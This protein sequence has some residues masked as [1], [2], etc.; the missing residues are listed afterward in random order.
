MRP[1]HA[2][3]AFLALF[4]CLPV[5]TAQTTDSEAKAKAEYRVLM[6]KVRKSPDPKAWLRLGDWIERQPVRAKTQQD[7]LRYIR[8]QYG[9]AARK[10][11]GDRDIEGWLRLAREMEELLD[12]DSVSR[13]CLSEAL[14]KNPTDARLLAALKQVK[15]G[16]SDAASIVFKARKEQADERRSAAEFR[17]LAQWCREQ[18]AHTSQAKDWLDY[19]HAREL[20][21]SNRGGSA[22]DPIRRAFD[23]AALKMAAPT[24]KVRDP[25]LA[26][27]IHLPKRKWKGLQGAEYKNGR[28]YRLEAGGEV[29]Y[30]DSLPG[31]DHFDSVWK[32]GTRT[33]ASQFSDTQIMIQDHKAWWRLQWDAEV[34]D[35]VSH[36]LA[37]KRS[38]RVKQIAVARDRLARAES[39]LQRSGAKIDKRP[40]ETVRLRQFAERIAREGGRVKDFSRAL[41]S[42]V[43][44]AGST[45]Y[46]GHKQVEARLAIE[47][48][49]Q[50]IAELEAAPLQ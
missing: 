20:Y 45:R 1:I 26:V 15:H 6:Q 37:E 4:T 50:K 35:W 31:S 30:S 28:L 48:W 27:G 19:A 43:N 3:L 10:K 39:A 14:R 2:L 18:I 36:T 12:S 22:T 38:A 16:Q 46:E 7:W 42:I 8:H 34:R 32:R 40:D 23:A 17:E 29:S 5:L 47:A 11:L 49:K 24:G 44:S 33:S 13:Q 9:V 25:H 21:L 41:Q